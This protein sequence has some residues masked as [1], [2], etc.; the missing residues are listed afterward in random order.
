[1][2]I[3][4]IVCEYNPFHS[5]HAY[6]IEETRRALGG[7]CTVI[8]VMSGNFVQRGDFAVF[9]KHSR[10]EA[11][12]RC[13]ADLVVELPAPYALSSAEGFAGAAV[14]IL[15]SFGICDNI[16]FGSELGDIGALREAA[17][18]IES[19]EA[20]VL[21]KKWAGTG[22]PYATA[23]QKAADAVLGARSEV[24]MTP[25]NLLG[26]EYLKAI[27][28]LGSRLTPITV[29]RTGTAHD[30]DTGCSAS[31]LRKTLLEEFGTQP[32]RVGKRVDVCGNAAGEYGGAAGEYGGANAS[33][34]GIAGRL[35]S[36]FPLS[37]IPEQATETYLEELAAG[38]APVSMK[39]GESAMLSRL[40]AAVDLSATPG[41]AEGLDRR[42]LRYSASEATIEAMLAKIKTK[43]Y[44]MSRLRR[45]LF[46]A[47][48]G[49]TKDDAE[50]PPPY[51]RVLAMNSAG[52]L[53]LKEARGK[54]RLPVITKPSSARKLTGRSEA[55]FKIEA[56]ATDFY[57]LAYPEEKER[58]G[59]QEWRVSPV[60]VDAASPRRASSS[61]L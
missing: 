45:M 37:C 23:R 41:A 19:E 46:C 38:R 61:P 49:I 31:A 28:R 43:R 27:S 48:L 5:G 18:A 57:A 2:S 52:M 26:V 53:L 34:H 29:K 3:V 42:F 10:A 14:S 24:F 51:I 30:S 33:A 35:L 39:A 17:E 1:M 40:R 16:S 20:G 4:G 8:C 21:I 59:G 9:R 7:D 25:N 36:R 12:V 44:A 50:Q 60:V 54:A 22:L 13:G 32:A 11:A 58:T 47:C 55:M 15:D 6:H 56:A